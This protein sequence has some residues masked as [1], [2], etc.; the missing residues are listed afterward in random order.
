MKRPN[1]LPQELDEIEELRAPTEAPSAGRLDAIRMAA[2]RS[3]SP[4]RPLPSTAT[5]ILFVVAGFLAFS[6]LATVPVGFFGYYCLLLNQKLAY[7]AVILLSA[8]VLAA[9]LVAEIIPGSKR[10]VAPGIS[11]ISALVAV[12]LVT[13]VLFPQPDFFRFVRR[14]LPCL[15]LGTLCAA[16][17]GFLVYL[18][19]RKGFSSAPVRTALAA[20]LLA[21]L[22][23]FA[24]LALHCPIL[25]VAHILVWHLGPMPIGAAVGVFLGAARA[26]TR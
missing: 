17:S 25:N 13:F 22:A 18:L 26:A 12:V 14:G 23:G 8:M 9:S 20:G 2:T 15:E 7:Y 16:T 4:V 1:S 11:M 24:V 3:L 6:V 21:G 10:R 5:L 19:I